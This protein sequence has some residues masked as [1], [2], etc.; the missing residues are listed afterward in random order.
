MT[1]SAPW[2]IL[3]IDATG[4]VGE[5]GGANAEAA[6][7]AHG[8][9]DLLRGV[10]FVEMDATLHRGD[11]DI[12]DF[13]DHQAAGVA[14]GGGTREA[15]NFFVGDARGFGQFVGEGAEAGAEDERD[16]RAQLGFREDEFRGAVGARE[17]GVAR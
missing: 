7:D 4:G 13:A 14:D 16:F 15:G 5:D 8:E 10:A 1:T 3:Q 9:R 6:E 11:G 2:L 17:F 12:F